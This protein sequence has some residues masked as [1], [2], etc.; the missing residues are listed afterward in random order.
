MFNEGL[1]KELQL[2]AEAQATFEFNEWERID[3]IAKEPYSNST[4]W[5]TLYKKGDKQFYLNITSAAKALQ[6]LQRAI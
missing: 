1:K 5:G 4:C 3:S 6:I 2:L